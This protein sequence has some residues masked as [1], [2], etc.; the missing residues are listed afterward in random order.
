V[1]PLLISFKNIPVKLHAVNLIIQ[2]KFALQ[3][4]QIS[5]NISISRKC[6]I[7]DVGTATP[8]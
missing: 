6:I 1:E 2:D 3:D 5:I 8:I 7:W 4:L